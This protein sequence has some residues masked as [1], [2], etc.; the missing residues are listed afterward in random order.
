MR[1]ISSG[2]GHTAVLFADGTVTVFGQNVP[3]K[4]C[5]VPDLKGKTV[6]QVSAGRCHTGLLFADGTVIFFGDNQFGQCDIPLLS[7]M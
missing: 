2:G 3:F 6:K 1:Q 7:G 5:E 4:Q